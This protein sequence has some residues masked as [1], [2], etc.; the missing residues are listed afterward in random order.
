MDVGKVLSTVPWQRQSQARRQGL[1]KGDTDAS[2]DQNS[3]SPGP[4]WV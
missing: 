4:L 1:D 3:E 2:P